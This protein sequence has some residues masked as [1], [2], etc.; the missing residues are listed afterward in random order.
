[1]FRSIV[2]ACAIAASSF[3]FAGEDF[4]MKY[5][6]ADFQDAKSVEEL[7]QRIRVTAREHCP[8]YSVSRSLADRRACVDDVSEQLVSKIDH[9]VLT[10]FVNGE[11][12]V[13]V[14]AAE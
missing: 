7:Y 2:G 13:E 11:S 12:P 1:M 10:A 3:A 6:S 8:S 4:S 9:P 5:S 14:A